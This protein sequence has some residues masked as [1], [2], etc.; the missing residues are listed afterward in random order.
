MFILQCKELESFGVE[1]VVLE[2]DT[3]RERSRPNHVFRYGSDV[4]VDFSEDQPDLIWY[5][6]AAVNG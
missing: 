1:T 6:A 4:G 3:D 5:Y 2:A